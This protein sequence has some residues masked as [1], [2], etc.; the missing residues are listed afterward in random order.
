M[1]HS[2]KTV[3]VT[4]ELNGETE[5]RTLSALQWQNIGTNEATNGGW[6]V[7]KPTEAKPEKK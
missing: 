7:A 5:T 4:R 3:T 6:K 2:G 1:K